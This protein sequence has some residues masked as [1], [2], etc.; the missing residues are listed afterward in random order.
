MQEAISSETS[1]PDMQWDLE[2]CQIRRL[3]DYGVTVSI[4]KYGDCASQDGQIGENV[5]L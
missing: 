3:S 5:G 2:K 1:L 4:F